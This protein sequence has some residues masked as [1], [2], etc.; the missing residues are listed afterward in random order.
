VDDGGGSRKPVGMI[1]RRQ[2]IGRHPHYASLTK[3][4]NDAQRMSAVNLIRHSFANESGGRPSTGWLE[5]AWDVLRA[6]AAAPTP[7]NAAAAS[8][9]ASRPQRSRAFDAAAV[10]WIPL[11]PGAPP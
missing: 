9:S 3:S 8:S 5:S 2:V 11:R 4:T 6:A 10:D 7:A 1:H